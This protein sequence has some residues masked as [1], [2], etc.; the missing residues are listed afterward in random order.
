MQTGFRYLMLYFQPRIP[1]P[2]HIFL[3]SH[4]KGTSNIDTAPY[5]A[6]AVHQRME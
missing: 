4:C 5:E 1:L 3:Q 2:R 6:S